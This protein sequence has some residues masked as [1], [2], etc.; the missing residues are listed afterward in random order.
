MKLTATY[1]GQTF[2]RTTKAAYTHIT[3]ITHPETGELVDARWSK[4]AEAAAKPLPHGWEAHRVAVI[5]VGSDDT[6][7]EVVETEK[8][9]EFEPLS[10]EPDAVVI[11]TFVTLDTIARDLSSK[12]SDLLD[13][14]VAELHRRG[15]QLSRV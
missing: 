1:R 12:E 7:A 5:E 11:E 4:S 14:A 2:T 3:V 10:V 9:P 13:R 15:I 6:V 8:T